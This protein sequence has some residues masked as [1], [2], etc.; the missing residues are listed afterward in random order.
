MDKREQLLDAALD[1]FV[2]QGFHRS[3]TAAISKHAGVSTGVLFHYF[4]TKEALVHALFLRTKLSLM[5]HATRALFDGKARSVADILR[6]IW[7]DSV[8]WALSHPL[9][10]RFIEQYHHTLYMEAVHSDAAI[11]EKEDALRSYFVSGMKDGSIQPMD[12]DLLIQSGYKLITGFVEYL[13]ERPDS[14]V[15]PKIREGAWAM[16]ARAVMVLK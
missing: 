2:S 10:F 9:E 7:E 11:R 8:E 12:A 15:D 14:E 6:R 13:L 1:L 16:F 4:E 5:T 3:P